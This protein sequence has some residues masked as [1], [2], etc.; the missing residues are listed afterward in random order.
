M[1]VDLPFTSVE[2]CIAG[3]IAKK[4]EDPNQKCANLECLDEASVAWLWNSTVFVI[5]GGR[6]LTRPVTM[7]FPLCAEHAPLQKEPDEP[8]GEA[9]DTP[10]IVPATE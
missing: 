7:W 2:E 8:D 5:A 3:G 9:E 1:E 10:L 6:M 4:I